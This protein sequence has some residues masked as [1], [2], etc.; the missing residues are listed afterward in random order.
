[1]VHTFPMI[2]PQAANVADERD[3]LALGLEVFDDTTLATV[4]AETDE[5]IAYMSNERQ[6]AGGE[7]D[8]E[9]VE[10]PVEQE[11]AIERERPPEW[12]LP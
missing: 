5:A 10:Y 2:A 3:D 12:S 8:D 11:E 1:M 6:F 9:I 7:T 4:V